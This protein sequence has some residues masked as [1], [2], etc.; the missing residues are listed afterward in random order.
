MNWDFL[1]MDIIWL[2]LG[3][4]FLILEM[5]TVT[6]FALLFGIAAMIT[7][8]LAWLWIDSITLQ[9]LLFA[10]FSFILILFAKKFANRISQDSTR[11][12]A[13]DEIIGKI[14]YVTSTIRADGSKGLVKI[15]G[16]EWRAIPVDD[17]PIEQGSKVEVL[18][19]TGV[20]LTVKKV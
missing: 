14:G 6:F 10:A 20:K 18:S 12:I 17:E 13:Q 11:K 9:I 3:F 8:L 4:L 1:G 2:I 16:E 5:F 15:L 7:A 19:L